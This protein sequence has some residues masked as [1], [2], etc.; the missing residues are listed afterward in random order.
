MICKKIIFIFKDWIKITKS[1]TSFPKL[2]IKVN[3]KSYNIFQ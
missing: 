1:N 2:V 3:S